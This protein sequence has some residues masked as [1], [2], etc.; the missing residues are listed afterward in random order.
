MLLN[1]HLFPGS[2]DCLCTFWK[3]GV[4]TMQLAQIYSVASHWINSVPQTACS[5]D[6]WLSSVQYKSF[7]NIC[8]EC[9]WSAVRA[10]LPELWVQSCH[11]LAAGQLEVCP[12]LHG[13]VTP[14]EAEVSSGHTRQ[15]HRRVIGHPC[16][17]HNIVFLVISE[18]AIQKR[19]QIKYIWSV[20]KS[21]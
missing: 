17:T 18:V 1:D 14:G 15:Q 10:V 5:D 20:R 21:T 11:G 19:R 16:C 9:Q 12:G 7:F 13:L 4:F 6:I 2:G 3:I 8:C